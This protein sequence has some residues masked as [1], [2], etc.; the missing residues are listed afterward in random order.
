MIVHVTYKF[1]EETMKGK[2]GKDFFILNKESRISELMKALRLQAVRTE[3]KQQSMPRPGSPQQASAD[4]LF[5]N[6][7][8]PD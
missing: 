8:S 7:Y 1:K 3:Q 4:G 6:L 2:S 5:L